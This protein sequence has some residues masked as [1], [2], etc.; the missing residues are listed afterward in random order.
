VQILPLTAWLPHALTLAN[1]LVKS[2]ANPDHK[3]KGTFKDVVRKT[4]TEGTETEA[5][6]DVLGQTDFERALRD[7][8]KKTFG[9]LGAPPNTIG[10][11]EFSG[12]APGNILIHDVVCPLEDSPGAHR[13]NHFTW[14][15][16]T[17]GTTH[18]LENTFQEGQAEFPQHH[19]RALVNVFRGQ[20]PNK[21]FHDLFRDWAENMGAQLSYDS[22]NGAGLVKTSGLLTFPKLGVSSP[23]T[24]AM[25]VSAQTFVRRTNKDAKLGV[26]FDEAARRVGK[27][28]AGNHRSNGYENK[29][30]PYPKRTTQAFYVPN[31]N[32]RLTHGG[33]TTAL[34][35]TQHAV[36][37]HVMQN[38]GARYRR[39]LVHMLT[40]DLHSPGD[41]KILQHVVNV[42]SLD[43]QN[44]IKKPEEIITF[45]QNYLN[46]PGVRKTVAQRLDL[47]D[48]QHR[49]LHNVFK[50]TWRAMKDRADTITHDQVMAHPIMR[51]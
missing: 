13:V 35:E 19:H 49:E 30:V 42:S 38:H 29:S 3:G 8:S 28:G 6:T 51:R 4:E 25:P 21:I 37:G 44:A 24:T 41:L 27:W 9:H 22:E 40:H 20:P 10:Y 48:T 5:E 17:F 16:D 43:P 2:L 32:P 23:P 46:D 26:S 12:D 39:A 11:V 1:A 36:F 50:R 14:L 15:N 31:D 18:N 7:Y 33:F 45:Y 34:H 47:N